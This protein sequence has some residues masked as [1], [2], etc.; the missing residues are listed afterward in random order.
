MQRLISG[1]YWKLMMIVRDNLSTN[2][3]LVETKR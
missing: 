2:K 3:A 1:E